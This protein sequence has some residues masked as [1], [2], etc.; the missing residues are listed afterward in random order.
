MK[1]LFSLLSACLVTAT[2]F[3]QQMHLKK[4][5]FTSFPKD[6]KR[7]TEV[8]NQ[9]S[10]NTAKQHPEYGVL[11]FNAQCSE[12]VEM[13]DQRTQNTRQ[14]IDAKNARRTYSQSSYFPLHYKKTENDIWRTIDPRLQSQGNG[15]YIAANQPV[16]TK[17]D[18]N[19]KSSFIQT[20]DFEF[21]F[22]KN[23]KLYFFDENSV[24]TQAEGGNYS[25]YTIGQEGLFVKNMWPGINMLQ[26]HSVGS[27]KTNFVVEAPLQLPI[28]KGW[29]VIQDEFNLPEGY[30]FEESKNGIHLPEGYQGDYLLRNPVGDTLVI[31]EKPVYVDAKAFGMHGAYKLLKDGNNYT[32]QT[33]VPVEWLNKVDNT[34]PLFIDPNVFGIT[35]LGNFR[36]SGNPSANLGFTSMALGSCDYH[37]NVTVPGKSTLTSAYVDLEYVLTYDNACGIPPLPPP[38]C[39]FSQVTMQVVNDTCG[40]STG[41][42][43]C[44]PAS[45]PYTGTCTSDSNLVAG[46]QSIL[47]NNFVPNY[48]TC[49]ARSCS[50]YQIAFTLKNQDSICGDVCGYLCA[51]GNTWQMTIVADQDSLLY[52][53]I[54]GDTLISNYITGNQWYL[55]DSIINGATGQTYI[56]NVAGVYTDRVTSDS[57]LVAQITYS[58]PTGIK[59]IQAANSKLSVI[60]NPSNGNFVVRYNSA[61]AF[62]SV[63]LRLFDAE[64]RLVTAKNVSVVAGVNNYTIANERKFTSGIYW[65][66]LQSAGKTLRQKVLIE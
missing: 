16:T 27:V 64:G 65:L 29:M 57:C 8:L 24:Y 17:C 14:F 37:M 21:E 30:T 5:D 10:S 39:T 11:P 66:E 25:D 49:I 4:P 19:R 13:I 40:T 46:A 9:M 36:W 1:K 34:Y 61:D 42:L 55:N 56:T 47:I 44:S 31:Y 2:A 3:S 18:L 32:L 62:T 15:I 20:G 63:E 35:R 52:L 60:P 53:T 38:Y 26:Q 50:D 58:Q 43:G 28:N 41:L 23:L 6:V 45:P 33:L 12:C 7:N 54:S 48:L 59:D 51:R 22:N